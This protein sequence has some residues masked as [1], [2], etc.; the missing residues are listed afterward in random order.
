[1]VHNSVPVHLFQVL[2]DSPFN[3]V[4]SHIQ[5]TIAMQSNMVNWVWKCEKKPFFVASYQVN[6]CC[7]SDYLTFPL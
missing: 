7:Y 5:H 6:L 4:Y 1:M 2:A 3:G